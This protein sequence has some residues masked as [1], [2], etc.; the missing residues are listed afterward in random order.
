MLSYILRRL[1]YTVVMVVVV[2]FVSFI[3]IDLPPGDA[4]TQE[5]ARLQALGDRSAEETVAA[6]RVRYGM[7]QPLLTRYWIWATH[8]VQGDFGQYFIY[9]RPVAEL[10][11]ERFYLTLTLAL[12][13]LLLTWMVAI[14]IGVYS[15]VKQY[16]LG[17]QIFT[18]ISFIGLGTPGFLLALVVLFVAVVILNQDVIGLFSRDFQDAPWSLAKVW[19]LLK[20]LWVPALIACVT[21]SASFMRIMRGNLLET[22]GQPFVEA[23]RARGLKNSTVI[24]KHAV[25]VAINPLIVILG[26]EQLPTIIAGNALIEWVLN[27]PTIGPLY[28]NALI[29]QEMY[30]AGTVLV[31]FVLTIMIGSL[32]AD[33]TLAALDPRIRLG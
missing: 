27:L 15:A 10:L 26:S 20:H 25:R 5:L 7:D 30:M 23:A 28:I 21:T 22:L 33:L 6:L 12:A 31:F 17:D 16:S 32:L 3:I 2:S 14:P 4:L 11:G 8:F 9:Q 1:G 24:W 19:D 29:R 13:T 18:T